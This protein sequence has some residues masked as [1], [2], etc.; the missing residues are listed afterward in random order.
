[1]EEERVVN[2]DGDE[3]TIYLAEGPYRT[4]FRNKDTRALDEAFGLD[5]TPVE[6][7]S[8][9]DEILRFSTGT[10][11]LGKIEVE[12]VLKH[13]ADMARQH[14]YFVGL[15]GQNLLDMMAEGKIYGHPKD[16]AIA[17]RYQDPV[18]NGRIYL[19]A[20][21]VEEVIVLFPTNLVRRT[22]VYDRWSEL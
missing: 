9:L 11:A 21:N 12:N 5:G 20:L 15:P 17:L 18:Q 19:K 3:V 8:E 4:V 16:V 1:M 13:F 6:E 22:E 2:V 10:N 7:G 14:G